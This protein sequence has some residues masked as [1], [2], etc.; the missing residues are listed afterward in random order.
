MQ[1]TG[2]S[3]ALQHTH[4]QRAGGVS[5]GK[6]KAA[7][8]QLICLEGFT[9]KCGIH[10]PALMQYRPSTACLPASAALARSQTHSERER[11][12]GVQMW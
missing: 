1:A 7:G 4:T 9:G 11:E 2:W 12:R 10:D 3:T 8:T 6:R 5:V